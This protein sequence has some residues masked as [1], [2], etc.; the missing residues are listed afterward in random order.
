LIHHSVT[1]LISPYTPLLIHPYTTYFVSWL[2][3]YIACFSRCGLSLLTYFLGWKSN[4]AI[5][6]ARCQRSK[7]GDSCQER[8]IGGCAHFAFAGLAEANTDVNEFTFWVY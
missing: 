8:V 5:V 1:F 4:A 6:E 3:K 2:S 7:R